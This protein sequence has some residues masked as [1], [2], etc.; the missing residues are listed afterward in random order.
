MAGGYSVARRFIPLV[1]ALAAMM[2][3]VVAAGAQS[4]GQGGAIATGGRERHAL[5]IG[6]SNYASL[7]RLSNP[8]NDATDM[9]KAL[10]S[11]GFTVESLQ[12]ADLAAMEDATMRLGNRLSSS[13][14][15][16]GFFYYAG[17]GVQSGGI[18]YLIPADAKIGSEAFLKTKA[19]PVQSIMEILQ[20]AR[21]GLNVVVLDACRD[22]PFSW[23]RS[24]SR[25]LTV[26]GAQPSGSIIVYATSA[27]S[28]ARDGAGRNGTFTQ[29]LLKYISQPGLEINEVFKRT[30]KAVG[31]ATNGVQVPAIYSQ[32][33]E[34]TY[35]AG[36]STIA[37]ADN[38]VNGST[39]GQRGAAGASAIPVSSGLPGQD[40][41]AVLPVDHAARARELRAE[42]ELARSS[43]MKLARAD[44]TLRGYLGQIA[45]LEETLAKIGSGFTSLAEAE[46][47]QIGGDY[48]AKAL[49]AT[50]AEM[51]PWETDREYADR[52]AANLA[53][54]ETARIVALAAAETSRGTEQATTEKDLRSL[55]VKAN[56]D[57]L[58]KVWTLRGASVRLEPQAFDREGKTWPVKLVSLDP[59]LS[60]S[61]TIGYSMKNVP[62]IATVYR[63]FEAG[64]KAGTIEGEIQY[65]Y[66]RLAGKDILLT[67]V[68]N[69]K[70]TDRKASKV[71]VT[72]G[73]RAIA[74]AS[75]MSNPDSRLAP[76]RLRIESDPS[77]ARVSLAGRDLGVTPLDL[78]GEIGSVQYLV[79]WA[80]IEPVQAELEAVLEYG[81]DKTIIA[82]LPTAGSLVVSTDPPGAT[83]SLDGVD[84]GTSPLTLRDL[85]PGTVVVKARK[86]GY[87]PS[88]QESL[89]VVGKTTKIDWILGKTAA[90]GDTWA[91]GIVFFVDDKGGG[92]VAAPTNQSSGANWDA[93][94]KICNDL[95]LNG[96]SDWRLPKK[97]ELAL[98][99]TN[100]YQAKRGGFIGS[101]YWSSSEDDTYRAIDLTFDSGQQRSSSKSDGDYVRAIRAF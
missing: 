4:S 31:S 82:K 98:M 49:E 83:I 19:L 39:T 26:V 57:L 27:G 18:N 23:M 2:T 17:H 3:A 65:G 46:K 61:G 38:P 66:E 8:V 30:G 90:I 79:T 22:N 15:A 67:V 75:R 76:P 97:E 34:S 74:Q 29:E 13:Q 48:D 7:S 47:R 1:L 40:A 32:F 56:A 21:N 95:V 101:Y 53:T 77:G 60:Y 71:L 36:M 86:D 6:N 25:G 42:I 91:G 52:K 51:D 68:K 20:G 33:F 16:I 58:A 70:L 99:C 55:L 89:I 80:D 64:L 69:L 100:L 94:V 62:D 87:T 85:A 11:L 88:S 93:A 81:E 5:V 63:S 43:G 50:T 96:F 14:G 35:L 10:E 44:E 73:L 12:D 9:T 45:S 59:A 78:A 37:L 41:P 84:R 72:T 24:G 92:L 28:V 54:V